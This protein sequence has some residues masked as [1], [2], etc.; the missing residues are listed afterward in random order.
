MLT[1]PQKVRQI[2]A[3]IPQLF[4]TDDTGLDALI[5]DALVDADNWL[6][7]Y[8]GANYGGVSAAEASVQGRASAYIALAY[9]TPVLKAKKVYGTHYPIDSEDSTSYENL[10]EQ[11][12]EGLAK[13]ELSKWLQIE[14]SGQG[15]SAKSFARPYFGIT[16]SPDP[17]LTDNE[18][19]QMGDI[20]DEARGFAEVNYTTVTR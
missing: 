9:L 18:E 1:T 19:I 3:L 20:A 2:G 4:D 7:T 17:T 10:L 11:D 5:M 13:S 6:Q 15:A 14:I 16:D 12:W 8:L